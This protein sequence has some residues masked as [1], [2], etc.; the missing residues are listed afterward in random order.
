MTAVSVAGRRLAYNLGW[1]DDDDDDGDDRQTSR[2]AHTHIGIY[3]Y[4][5]Y[6][7]VNGFVLL[8]CLALA[9]LFWIAYTIQHNTDMYRLHTWTGGLEDWT[10]LDL[11]PITMYLVPIQPSR[12]H[13]P[14]TPWRCYT[15]DTWLDFARRDRH[16]VTRTDGRRRRRSVML[17]I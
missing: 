7:S 14:T 17:I 15:L 10:G 6:K 13:A 8:W 16:A 11:V 3:T 5:Y 4:Y 12:Q 1:N 9:S 2:G